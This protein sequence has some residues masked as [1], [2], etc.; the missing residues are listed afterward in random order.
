[1][2]IG[3]LLKAILGGWGEV[4]GGGGGF[5]KNNNNNNNNGVEEM[6]FAFFFGFVIL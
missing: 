5:Q 6:A 1:M 2:V 3:G 4:G